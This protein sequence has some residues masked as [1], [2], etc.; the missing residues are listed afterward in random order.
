MMTNKTSCYYDEEDKKTEF[1]R[2]T[3]ANVI[4]DLWKEMNDVAS[5]CHT[6]LL[7]QKGF[8]MCLAQCCDCSHRPVD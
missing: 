7:K 4:W 8:E 5:V 6:P 1:I 3:G 2:H